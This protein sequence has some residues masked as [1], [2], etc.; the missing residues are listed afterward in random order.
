MNGQHIVGAN[1]ADYT[2]ENVGLEDEGQYS[3]QV[4]SDNQQSTSQPATLNL[5]QAISLADGF[6]QPTWIFETDAGDLGWY[7]Q[8]DYSFDK[9][10]AIQSGAVG[11]LQ[12]SPFLPG[13]GSWDFKFSLESVIGRRP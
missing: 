8:G 1:S 3:V 2:I 11:D 13:S 9:V 7:G 12:T 10:D 6:D 4:T 5:L